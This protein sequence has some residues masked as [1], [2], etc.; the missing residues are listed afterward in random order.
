MKTEKSEEEKLEIIMRQTLM[1]DREEI[2]RKLSEQEN[3]Y[4]K[5]I[6]N[7][8]DIV[9]PKREQQSANVE[10][11]RQISNMMNTSMKEHRESNP[12]KY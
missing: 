7:Y 4:E 3:D 11:Y 10:I 5:V 2:K 12:N 8:Y 1:T 6:M 9:K